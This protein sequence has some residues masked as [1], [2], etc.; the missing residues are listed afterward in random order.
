MLYA[1]VNADTLEAAASTFRNHP[2][3][4]IPRSSI[5]VMELKSHG[6]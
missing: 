2:H 4:A 6:M 3:L 1:I 5:E